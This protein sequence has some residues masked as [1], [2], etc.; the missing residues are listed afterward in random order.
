MP[1]ALIS[2]QRYIHAISPA[3]PI[4]LFTKSQSIMFGLASGL[5]Q[6]YLIPPE[7]S[8]LIVGCD[9]SG[10]STLLER[11]KVTDF[12]S[13][14]TSGKRIA[15]QQISNDFLHMEKTIERREDVSPVQQRKSP[16]TQKTLNKKPRPKRRLFSC[17]APKMYSQSRLDS[18]EETELIES[19][20]NSVNAP[21]SPKSPSNS[22]ASSS[23]G[24]IDLPHGNVPMSPVASPE[25]AA[26]SQTADATDGRLHNGSVSALNYDFF[27]GESD[28]KEHDLKAGKVMFPLHL[29]RPTRE[30]RPLLVCIHRFLSQLHAHNTFS[31]NSLLWKTIVGM[32]LGKIEACGAKIRLM[33]LGGQVKMR[34]LWERY[35]NGIHAITFVLDVSPTCEVSKLME[36][37]A[38]YRCMRDDESLRNVPILIFANKMDTRR[39]LDKYN[40][41]DENE[42]NG[43]ILGDTSLL[44]IAE[45][46]LSHPK[47]SRDLMTKLDAANDDDHVAF[48][49]GSAKTGEGVRAA[50]DWL[51][52]MGATRAR[53]AKKGE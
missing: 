46:F 24:I 15:V 31:L 35:Y 43:L 14:E 38:F 7:V 17:P 45:L 18:D 13:K 23:D 51:I 16:S 20:D 1:Y 39:L 21:S 37:R 28:E 19:V 3:Q 11:V 25:R 8:I 47:G 33:D 52:Q 2:G 41:D 32:N 10:K 12:D 4:H 34:P 22:N 9:D 6:T 53:Q 49:A 42:D 44:D 48:F 27:Q 29:I 36:A 26:T 30:F 40:T 50:F 5:Y